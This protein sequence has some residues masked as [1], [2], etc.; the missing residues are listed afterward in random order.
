[1]KYEEIALAMQEEIDN[2]LKLYMPSSP[3]CFVRDRLI[4]KSLTNESKWFWS[5]YCRRFF[6]DI[7][8]DNLY[9]QLEELAAKESMPAWGTRGT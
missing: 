6:G 2:P 9:L 8:L 5:H 4:K 7:G 1:M 3:G